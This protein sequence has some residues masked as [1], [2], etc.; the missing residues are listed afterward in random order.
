MVTTEMDLFITDGDYNYVM[1]FSQ[2]DKLQ[3][4]LTN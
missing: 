3:L 4:L 2:V 1:N